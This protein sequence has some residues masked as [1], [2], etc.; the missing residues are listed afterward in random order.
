V[1]AQLVQ[2][3]DQAGASRKFEIVLF[4]YD[5]DQKAIEGYLKKS[6]MAFPAVTKADLGK[7][8]SLSKTGDTGFIPNAVL[9]TRDGKLVT[10]DLDQLLQ[11]LRN[12]K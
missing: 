9:V 7:V 2:L 1:T 4:G 5:R 10:N 11:T 12:L 3:Y 6:H 8:K